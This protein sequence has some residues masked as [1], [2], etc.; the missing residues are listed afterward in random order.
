VQDEAPAASPEPEAKAVVNDPL[1]FPL[2]AGGY[3]M[4]RYIDGKKEDITLWYDRESLTF[5][6]APKG[7]GLNATVENSFPL[8]TVKD[9]YQGKETEQLQGPLAADVTAT[10]C[11]SIRARQSKKKNKQAWE[12]LL[13]CQV[14]SKEDA[15]TLLSGASSVLQEL[16]RQKKAKKRN[17]SIMQ[18]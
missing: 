6:W 12:K 16:A 18:R 8:V 5:N 15:D 9:L 2:L 4:I 1:A 7:T 17:K 11:F 3:D 13:E 14:S 10:L